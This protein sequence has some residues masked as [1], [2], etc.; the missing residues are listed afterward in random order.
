MSFKS[1]LEGFAHHF[2][3]LN[4]PKEGMLDLLV[5]LLFSHLHC[6]VEKSIFVSAF[7]PPHGVELCYSAPESGWHCGH[8]LFVDLIHPIVIGIHINHQ[9]FVDFLANLLY[10][11]FVE[12]GLKGETLFLF[13]KNC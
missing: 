13:L 5:K 6:T 2:N 8:V 4:R 11:S 7:F 3:C 1:L 9:I 10:Y 12:D